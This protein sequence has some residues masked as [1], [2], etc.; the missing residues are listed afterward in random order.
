MWNPFRRRRRPPALP[1]KLDMP[2]RYRVEHVVTHEY[3]P[4]PLP[5]SGVIQLRRGGDVY[6]MVLTVNGREGY[7]TGGGIP[8]QWCGGEPI[9]LRLYFDYD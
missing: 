9:E 1:A 7:L 4:R 6:R 8:A 5:V 2:T 3:T